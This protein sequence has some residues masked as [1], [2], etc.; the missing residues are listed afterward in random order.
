M[1]DARSLLKLLFCSLLLLTASACGRQYAKG[2][3]ID[4]N[5]IILRSDKFV[6]ADL[7]QIADRLAGSLMESSAVSKRPLLVIERFSNSTDEHID[8]QSLMEKVQV[9][10]FK[11]GKVRITKASAPYTLLGNI[12]A[13]KQPVG[14]QEI[15]YYKAT[16]E[17]IDSSG[18]IHW[19]DD[20][21]LKKHF[22]KKYTGF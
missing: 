14:R 1:M 9:I 18:V 5:V 8:T 16:L 12:S 20:V 19:T 3:Y 15:V 10:L 6:E 11:S 7:Q 2:E 17:L 4:P 22:R 21:E 13:I